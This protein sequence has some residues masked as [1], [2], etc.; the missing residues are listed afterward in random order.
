[1]AHILS[2]RP[3]YKWK[4]SHLLPHYIYT[5]KKQIKGILLRLLKSREIVTNKNMVCFW[6]FH[7]RL[8]MATIVFY[9]CLWIPLLQL[10]R[11]LLS[12][13]FNCN[14]KSRQDLQG[15]RPQI[16]ELPATMYEDLQRHYCSSL[17]GSMLEEEICSICLLKFE[18]EDIVSKLPKCGHV[19]HVNCIDGWLLRNYFTCPLCRSF[20]F[21]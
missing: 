12:L 20:L 11:T 3:V 17:D 6:V 21:S 13:L 18:G 14:D 19:Y 9:T 2:K 7:T 8:S 16:P 15:D 5:P 1:M 4:R 10:K